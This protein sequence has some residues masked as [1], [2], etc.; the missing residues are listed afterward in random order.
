MREC[1]N[2]KVKDRERITI[3]ENQVLKLWEVVQGRDPCLMDQG[4]NENRQVYSTEWP[5]L[6]ETHGR[7]RN[8]N[9]R[10]AL[11]PRQRG[12]QEAN[13]IERNE[14]VENNRVTGEVE[15]NSRVENSEESL[16]T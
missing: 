4:G 6:N 2:E 1:V 13:R 8:H 16:A 15:E 14:I 12:R 3:L 10:Y 7:N 11:K 9:E 5:R